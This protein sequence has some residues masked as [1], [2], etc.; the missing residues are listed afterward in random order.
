MITDTKSVW[1][2]GASLRA[3]SPHRDT[4]PT[5]CSKVLSRQRLSRRWSTCNPNNSPSYL[6]RPE[7]D[8]W[9]DQALQYLEDVHT[10]GAMSDLSFTVTE[11]RYSVRRVLYPQ[12][13]PS[14]AP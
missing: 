2:E 1:V 13:S 11:S 8:S 3:L 5:F 12:I 4:N 6:S 7:E 9:L 10:L 14:H